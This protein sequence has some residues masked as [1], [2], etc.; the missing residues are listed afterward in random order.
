MLRICR[1]KVYL[2]KQKSKKRKARLSVF[3]L[4]RLGKTLLQ[5]SLDK[6]KQLMLSN[7]RISDIIEADKGGVIMTVGDK[8]QS[9]RKRLGMSQEELGQKLLVSRQTISLWENGQTVPTIDNLIRLKEVFN[10]SVDDI[11][12]VSDTETEKQTPE[13]TYSFTFA[14]NELKELNRI[15]RSGVYKKLIIFTLISLVLIVGLI[16]A[17]ASDLA[18]GF[19]AGC[20]LVYEAFMIKSI[21]V[22]NKA[23]KKSAVRICA[24]TYEYRIFDNC[25]TI[26]IYRNNE[27]IRESKYS[28]EDIEQVRQAG[29]FILIKFSG[30]LYII[31]KS[32]LKENSFFYAYMYKNPEKVV[33]KTAPGRWKTISVILFVFSL[34]SILGAL[35]TVNTISGINGMFTENMWIFYLWVPVP[36]ASTIYG[37]VMSTKD[38]SF[39]KNIIAGLIMIALLCIYGSFSFMFR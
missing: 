27:K 31:R 2:Q 26:I 1:R 18:I 14:E 11:L 30:Q 28:F 22:Y 17:Q 38:Y 12:D 3:C 24:S 4:Q 32:E 35:V 8:I 21:A 20:I 25:L 19:F 7:F 23:W 5:V 34:L 13:E 37:F 16:Y 10:V 39:K 9:Y 36:L 15:Q 29:K 6:I 33:E